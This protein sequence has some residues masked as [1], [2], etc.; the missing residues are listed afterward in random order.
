M[1]QSTICL[2]SAGFGGRVVRPLGYR[3]SRKN[4]NICAVCV[5]LAPPGGL[6][7]D[8]GVLFADLRGFTAFSAGSKATAPRGSVVL[9]SSARP[10]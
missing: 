2:R 7:T 6:T 3:P 1:P 5:E 9:S 4:P 8:V 10:R